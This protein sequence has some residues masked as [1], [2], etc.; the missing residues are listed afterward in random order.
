MEKN[1]IWENKCDAKKIQIKK[2]FELKLIEKN[3]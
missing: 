3:K 2:Y 1:N